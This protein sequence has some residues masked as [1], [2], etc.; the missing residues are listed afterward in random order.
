VMGGLRCRR[1]RSD[2]ELARSP[3]AHDEWLHGNGDVRA[4]VV[5]RAWR[6]RGKNVGRPLP[7]RVGGMSGFVM[8]IWI[9]VCRMP[10]L[11]CIVSCKS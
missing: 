8:G 4:S 9:W 10:L 7:G 1:D 11:I 2:S 6:C 5:V 3:G